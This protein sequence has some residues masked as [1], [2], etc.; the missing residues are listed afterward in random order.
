[1]W[2]NKKSQI[3]TKKTLFEYVIFEI[4]ALEFIQIPKI[5]QNN[6]DNSINKKWDQKL[7]YLGIFLTSRFEKLLLYLKLTPSNL[8]KCNVWCKNKNPKKKQKRLH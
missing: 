3:W 5:E 4:K 2:K 8:S 7:L 1:M 6:N